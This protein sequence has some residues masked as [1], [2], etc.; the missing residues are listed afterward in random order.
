M[1]ETELNIDRYIGVDI[2]GPLIAQNQQ[3][4]GNQKREFIAADIIKDKL[5][6]VDLILCRD[7]LVH[8]SFRDDFSAIRNFKASQSRFLLATTYSD[9]S[10]NRDIITGKWRPLNLEE[11]PFN[12]PAPIKL[13]N[14]KCTVKDGKY[15][16]KSLGLWE[17]KDVLV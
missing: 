3:K 2:V 10:D 9:V 12:F 5:P 11:P 16:D 6:C 17:L 8:L 1:K 14:E 7:C 13:I 4:Y 15:A